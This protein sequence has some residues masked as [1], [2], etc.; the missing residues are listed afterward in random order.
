[1]SLTGKEFE[2]E[3][4]RSDL[5]EK[6]LEA[7]EKMA[8]LEEQ[9]PQKSKPDFQTIDALSPSNFELPLKVN[10]PTLDLDKTIHVVPNQEIS[11]KYMTKLSI[12]HRNVK[13]LKSASINA[14]SLGHSRAPTTVQSHFGEK[15]K[16]TKQSSKGRA[17]IMTQSLNFVKNLGFYVNQKSKRAES[18]VTEVEH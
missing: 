17:R 10:Q 3:Q 12:R 13:R 15:K 9:P 1:M 6:I 5:K 16:K 8:E 14:S 18:R 11:S 7:R 2:A 4:F